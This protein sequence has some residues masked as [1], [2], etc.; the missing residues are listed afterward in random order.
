MSDDEVRIESI[1]WERPQLLVGVRSPSE[2][3]DAASFRLVRTSGRADAMPP[4]GSARTD[5]TL[6]LR[7]NVTVGPGVRPLR[8]G[9]WRLSYASA[10]GAELPVLVATSIDLGPV[11]R[12]FSTPRGV[13]RV[14]PSVDPSDR[15]LVLDVALDPP[16]R[17]H[18]RGGRL[19]RALGEARRSLTDGR[20]WT[21]LSFRLMKLVSRRSGR[22]VLFITGS[23]AALGGNLK[24][25][26][27]R[28]LERG[29]DRDLD[30]RVKMRRQAGRPI[31][32]RERVSILWAIAHA[33]TILVEASRQKLVYQV[34]LDPDVRLIQLWHA[35]GAFKT[36]RYSRLGQTAGPD[37]W[38][39]THRN[40]THAIVSSEADVR[41]YA[42]AFGIPEARVVP[43]GI[44]RMDRYFDETL[45]A[46]GQADALAAYPETEGRM[47]IL[48]A[49]TYRDTD[50]PSG[51]TYPMEIIDYAELHA[52]CVERDAV[53]IIRMHPLAR[54]DLRIPEAFRDRLLDGYRAAINVNDLLFAVDLLITDYSSIVFEYSTL[55]RPMLFFAYDLEE[56]TASRDFYVPFES[57]VPGRIVRTF[58][59]LLD[60]IRRD[61]YQVEKV[62]DFAARH[63]A[64][65]DSGS[66][67]RVIDQL[68]LR[69]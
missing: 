63:F 2:S 35:S 59:E 46:K 32:W 31:K 14:T 4:T 12:A 58:P 50:D 3:V 20:T 27:D 43:T 18:G 64:Y 36:V 47:T 53:F 24:I 11:A 60:A 68:I 56:Y 21:R 15:G 62:A 9:R 19:R 6:E 54:Q 42:E 45:R 37:P 22:R 52:L 16:S 13:Y 69:G 1:G 65:L 26:H 10:V 66:T 49:P 41:F 48:F 61:D 40:Y 34:D 57:F 25:V 7:F 44:P 30:I 5:D 51:G 55:G 17:R 8:P 67:D 38:S 23:S 39:R 28:M 29:L 33:D